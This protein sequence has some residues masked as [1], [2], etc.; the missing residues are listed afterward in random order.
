[1]EQTTIA[2]AVKTLENGLIILDKAYWSASQVRCKDNFY[3]LISAMQKE[4]NELAKLSVEDHYMGYEPI[5]VPF[6]S[7]VT[8]FKSLQLELQE[9]VSHT[10]TAT[11]LDEA[12]PDILYLLAPHQ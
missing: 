11:A 8:K 10:E 9:W 2:Q 7:T 5:T 1:M 12:L 4:L 3:D 6:K